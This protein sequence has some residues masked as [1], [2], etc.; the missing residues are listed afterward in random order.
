M[1]YLLATSLAALSLN[2]KPGLP[3]AGVNGISRLE[4]EHS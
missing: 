2:K 1:W 4:T 3:D